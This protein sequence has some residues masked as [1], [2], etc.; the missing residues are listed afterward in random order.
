MP[1]PP[2]PPP[3]L[4]FAPG[5]AATRRPGMWIALFTL[6]AIM[7]LGAWL[8]LGYADQAATQPTWRDDRAGTPVTAAPAP[9]PMAGGAIVSSGNGGGNLASALAQRSVDDV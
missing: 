7:G 6:C 2:P 9:Q 4:P 3:H 5:S 8:T 1:S